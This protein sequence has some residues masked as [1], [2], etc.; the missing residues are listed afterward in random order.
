MSDVLK[1]STVTQVLFLHLPVKR[2][3]EVKWEKFRNAS[4]NKG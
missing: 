2:R 4:K 1:S 3:T